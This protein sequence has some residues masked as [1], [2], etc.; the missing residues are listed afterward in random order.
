[1]SLLAF[2]PPRHVIALSGGK[3]STA[4][5]LALHEREPRDYDYVITPTGNELPAMKV[6]WAKL[7]RLLGKELI[8]P[9]NPHTL[10]SLIEF[11]NALPNQRMRWCT[12][13]LKIEPVLA[14]CRRN[15]PV[16]MYVGLRADEERAGIYGDT[17]ESDFPFQRWGWVLDDVWRILGRHGVVIPERTDCALCYD[18]QLIEWWRLWKYN[19]DFWNEGKEHEARTGRT[20]RSPSRD[21]WPAALADLQKEFE[22]GRVP[23]VRK[24]AGG[25]VCR[26]CSL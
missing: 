22:R 8:R 26:V 17:V 9:P 5:A 24:S 20:F 18:Q 14:W 6:H 19:R 7:E 13:Q 11:H 21:T 25:S 2:D 12:R 15:A 1:M 3:D 10:V 4:L 23:P 16:I